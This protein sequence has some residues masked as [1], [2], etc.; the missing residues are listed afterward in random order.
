MKVKIYVTLTVCN[1]IVNAAS[2]LAVNTIKVVDCILQIETWHSKNS[3]RNTR[4]LNPLM[5]NYGHDKFLSAVFS[6]VDGNVQLNPKYM[7]VNKEHTV[8]L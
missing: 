2:F 8:K 1:Y 5:C 6:E 7:Q 3:K 4:A